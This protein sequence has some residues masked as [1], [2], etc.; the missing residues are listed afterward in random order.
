MKRIKCDAITHTHI[1]TSKV[2][3]H[4]F[5]ALLTVPLK[6]NYDRTI[7]KGYVNSGRLLF[8]TVIR[9]FQCKSANLLALAYYL[10]NDCISESETYQIEMTI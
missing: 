2:G 6:G 1:L 10:S 7:H 3:V 9:R 4:P 5:I 8:I